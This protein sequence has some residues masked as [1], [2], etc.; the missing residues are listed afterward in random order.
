MRFFASIV[1]ITATIQ[2]FI[3]SALAAAIA[4]WTR[5]ELSFWISHVKGVPYQVEYWKAFL[6]TLFLPFIL[7]ANAVSFLVRMFM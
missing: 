7:A 1:V 5:F 6:L 4:F 3:Y 2:L